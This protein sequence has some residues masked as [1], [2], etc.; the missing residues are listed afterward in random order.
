MNIV[1]TPSFFLIGA[2]VFFMQKWNN[3]ALAQL[4]LSPILLQVS[5]MFPLTI[6]RYVP[7]KRSPAVS[8]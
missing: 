4:K 6:Q 3:L 2:G 5:Y 7:G 1:H 8:F